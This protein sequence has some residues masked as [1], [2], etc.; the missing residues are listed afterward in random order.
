[1]L[2][3]SLVVIG[4]G[5]LLAP[6]LRSHSRKVALSYLAT[7]IFEGVV[8]AMGAIALLSMPGEAALRAN[9]LAYNVA[10]VGLGFGSLFFCLL[11]FRAR[12][13]FTSPTTTRSPL[14]H[15]RRI[16]PPCQYPGP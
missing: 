5:I 16:Q 9:F 4:I 3:N 14:R 7:R 10:M 2:L 6:V 1:M 12:L 8:L 11:L 15:P 13:R